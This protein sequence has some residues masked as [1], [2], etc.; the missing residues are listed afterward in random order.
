[1]TFPVDPA[2]SSVL[3]A[4]QKVCQLAGELAARGWLPATSGNLSVK[5]SDTPLVIAITASGWDKQHLSEDGVI[6]VDQHG[7]LV[8]TS[9]EK[10]SA[11]TAVHTQLYT[12]LGCGAVLHVHT[13]YN[14]L[15][16]DRYF[17]SGSVPLQG[18]ELLKA[19]GHWE[20]NA[21]I[22]VPIV[23][24]HPDLN[25]L[26]D[27]VAAVARPDVPGVLVRN[28][29]VYAWGQTPSDAKR[30]LEALEWLFEYHL[31]RLQYAGLKL[32]EPRTAD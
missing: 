2:A 13:L 27:A 3:A 6:L 21:R 25:R 12:R 5:V 19:L 16:S 17:P 10:P 4:R 18:Y 15:A 29:G 20:E 9:T 7:Q 30:H 1:M 11:E 8:E 32:A 22:E 28:H 23:E 14:N 24:N 31:L 26:A